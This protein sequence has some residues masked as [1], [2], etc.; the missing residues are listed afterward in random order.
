MT[1]PQDPEHLPPQQPYAP[2]SPPVG[3]YGQAGG[4]PEAPQALSEPK[5]L[6]LSFWLWITA[7]A[8]VA[9]TS[10]LVM[11][12]RES[13]TE[14]ARRAGGTQGLTEEQFQAAVTASLLFL[15]VLGL[16]MGGLLAFFA[17]KARAGRGWA[18]VALTVL[19]ALVFVYNVLGFSLLGLLTG[20]VV[21]VAMVTLHLPAT[22]QH[23]DAVK[24]AG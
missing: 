5:E 16:V 8:L 15:L 22:K 6:R 17:V 3:G 24:R 12:Q 18:R 2:G 4:P 7:A 1:T 19:G 14:A 9:L 20:L 10:L 13:A 23:F 21:A 11:T